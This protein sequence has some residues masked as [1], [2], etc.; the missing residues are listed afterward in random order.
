[1]PLAARAP[2]SLPIHLHFGADLRLD[3]DELFRFCQLNRELRIERSANGDLD[4]MTPVG[5]EGS[6]RNADLTFALVRW[7]REDGT[8]VAFDSSAGF[9]LPNGAMRS[10][11][12]AWLNRSRWE[13]LTSEERE[14]FVPVCPEFV[15]ELRSRTDSPASLQD[16]MAEWI[17]NGVRLGWLLDPENRAVHVY[18]PGREVEILE[19]PRRVSGEPELPGFVLELDVIWR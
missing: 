3:D 15:V 9:L 8:G 7:T 10:P 12:A 2:E 6:S 5:G 1:M 4:I 14:K 18:R 17:G 11:D 13:E 16:K 19:D